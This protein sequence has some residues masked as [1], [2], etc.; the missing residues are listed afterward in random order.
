MGE[1]WALQRENYP[2]KNLAG[3]FSILWTIG[4]RQLQE[5]DLNL[6]CLQPGSLWIALNH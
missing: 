1:P 4:P 2:L 6:P 3:E 5:W